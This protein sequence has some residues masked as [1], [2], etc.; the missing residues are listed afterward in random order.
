MSQSTQAAEPGVGLEQSIGA[1]T[2]F[3]IRGA[4]EETFSRTIESL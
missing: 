2:K 4:H 1:R 3:I